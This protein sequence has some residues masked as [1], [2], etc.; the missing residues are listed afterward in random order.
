MGDQQKIHRAV[1]SRED[2][3]RHVVFVIAGLGAGGAERV[4]SLISA[5]WVAQGWR[6]TILAFDR[7]EEPV[8]H[9]FD[10]RVEIRL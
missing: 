10:P 7:P 3:A 5:A 8:Y 4:I 6:V 1:G 2:P 9:D